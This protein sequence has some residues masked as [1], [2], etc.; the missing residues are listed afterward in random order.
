MTF[1]CAWKNLL[2]STPFKPDWIRQS[3]Q[4]SHRRHASSAAMSTLFSGML[5]PFKL[6]LGITLKSYR[7]SLSYPGI[8]VCSSQ[9]TSLQQQGQDHVLLFI[10]GW[11]L[12]PGDGSPDQESGAATS[13]AGCGTDLLIYATLATPMAAHGASV[14]QL[15]HP[16]NR[17]S[18][19]H[20]CIALEC[21][22]TYGLLTTR[23]RPNGLLPWVNTSRDKL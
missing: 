8:Q 16:Y 15:S 10:L 7:A 13:D 12:E 21:C 14:S 4:F 5:L 19:Q 11:L 18:T 23:K 17:G 9:T 6:A 1:T 20:F 2:H 3:Q 22:I